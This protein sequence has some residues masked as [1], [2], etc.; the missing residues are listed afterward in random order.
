M[1]YFFYRIGG[2]DCIRISNLSIPLSAYTVCRNVRNN[3]SYRFCPNS[4]VTPTTNNL[5]TNNVFDNITF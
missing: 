4:V 5:I 2:C 3:C 1:F